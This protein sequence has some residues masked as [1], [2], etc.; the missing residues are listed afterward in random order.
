MAHIVRQARRRIASPP[1]RAQNGRKD[2]HE[3]I[4][5]TLRTPGAIQIRTPA[6]DLQ[7]GGHFMRTIIA[8][9]FAISLFAP[10]AG[11]QQLAP[12]DVSILLP[13]PAADGDPMLPLPEASF[14]AAAAAS[15]AAVIAQVGSVTDPAGGTRAI[16]PDLLGARRGQFHVASIR[17]DP[18][19]PGLAPAFAPFGRS[20]QLR[21]VVQPV[22]FDNG[23]ASVRD[24]AVHLVYSFGRSAPSATCPFRS[25]PDIPAFAAA[26]DDLQELKSD[27]ANL[28]VVTDGAALGIHPAFAD[29]AATALIIERLAD[30]IA[31]HATEAR[32]SAVSV[33]GIPAGAPEPWIFVAMQRDRSTGG[34]QPVPGPAIAQQAAA[35][36]FAQM[37]SFASDFENGEVIPAGRTRNRLPVDCL[38]NFLVPDQPGDGDGVATS[39]LF[40]AGANTPAAAA[41][42]AAI[43]A[44]PAQAHFFNTDCV[45]CHSETRREIDAAT[46]GDA[47]SAAIAAAEGIDPA[48]MPRGPDDSGR[49]FDKWNVR[50][51]GWYPGFG[52]AGARAHAT[53]VRR[54]ARETAD[55]LACL[56]SGDW[57]DPSRPCPDEAAA[58]V[59]LAQGWDA[60]IRARFYHTSQGGRLMPAAYFTAL[61]R[62][63]GAGAFVAPENLARYGLVAPDPDTTGLNPLG[64]PPGLALTGT[65]AA[66]DIGLNCAAC[67]TG[68][69]IAG[70]RRLRIDGAPAAFDFDR[71]LADLATAIQAT[72]QLDFTQD[73]PA[74]T[75]RLAAFLQKVAATAPELAD[76]DRVLDFAA[77]FTGRAALRRPE[78]PSG[79][80]RVDAL[81]QIVNALAVTDLGVPSNL[82]TPA[83]PASY[84]ALWLAPRLEFVQ[85]NLS[86]ADPLARNIGQAQGVF[87]RTELKPGLPFDSSAD[88]AALQLYET[89]LQDLQP[90]R[91][92]ED[93]LGPIDTALAE[94]GRDLFADNCEG[95]H[96][97]PPFRETAAE[98]N[99][100]GERF[101]KVAAIPQVKAG[102]DPVYTQAL[103][104]RWVATGPLEEKFGRPLVPAGLF[105]REV[106][107]DTTRFMLEKAGVAPDQVP[108][109]LRLRPPGHP[110]CAADEA[111]PCGYAI[112]GGG[113]ALKAAPLLGVWATGPY[114]HNGSVRTVYQVISPPEEREARFWVGDR[115]LDAERLGF[116]STEAAGAYLFDTAVPGNSAGGHVFWDRPFTHE[117]RLALIEYL[118]DPERFPMS[119]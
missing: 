91:W 3:T 15:A 53:V 114:L 66:A 20:P 48:A 81:T 62:L 72:A 40:A 36:A 37:L 102:T 42:I 10:S 64:L 59:P 60:D 87:G 85:W 99:L 79:P 2:R 13:A 95:C 103:L 78:H 56:N 106:V 39:A 58:A 108:T 8:L 117:E 82:R 109:R 44:D 18:G 119:R 47:A 68:D 96:N 104:G 24:E 14:P 73:P 90:P 9:A 31:T 101:I 65:G 38:A 84:P 49:A 25:E 11:A 52:P 51:F 71:F 107:G 45:S 112:P 67:H 33:A 77:D 76:P 26:V 74:P 61:Q 6:E 28:G 110:D 43:V 12:A 88:I 4:Q 19:A 5:R 75:P 32:L 41:E 93:I 50:A 118:K 97:A 27:L 35:P 70:D 94:T 46:D 115:R 1:S 113:A 16:D 86:A 54:T 55:V 7:N 100:T 105:F 83:A 80:G 116:V 98:D 22:S 63:D 69:V 92:P 30:F 23:R 111:R 57:R 21:L 89:W 17:L 34:F 29:S